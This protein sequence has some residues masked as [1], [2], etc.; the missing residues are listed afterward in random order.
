MDNRESEDR[1]RRPLGEEADMVEKEKNERRGEIPDRRD[2]QM[3]RR[4]FIDIGWTLENE[5]RTLQDDR[6]GG[7]EDRRGK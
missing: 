1:I 4:Q 7:P 5:R 3:D 6:R 2:S